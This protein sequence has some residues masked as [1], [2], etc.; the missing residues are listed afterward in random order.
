MDTLELHNLLLQ[1]KMENGPR[2]LR[3]DFQFD[4]LF[5]PPECLCQDGALEDSS[6][7]YCPN[8]GRKLYRYENK[9][10]D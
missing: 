8:C 2:T 10:G 9:K 6:W 3:K 5:E 4:D 7:L 1:D